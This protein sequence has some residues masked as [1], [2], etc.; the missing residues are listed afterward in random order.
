M[1]T[2]LNPSLM[3]ARTTIPLKDELNTIRTEFMRLKLD[4]I[5]GEIH[6]SSNGDE[7]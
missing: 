4:Y 5:C 2:T 7:G 1:T 6:R 3:M